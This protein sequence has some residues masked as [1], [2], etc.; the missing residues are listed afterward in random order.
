[1]DGQKV[2]RHG[3]KLLRKSRWMA[4][5][6]G[7]LGSRGKRCDGWSQIGR[8][9]VQVNHEGPPKTQSRETTDGGGDGRGNSR[10][11]VRR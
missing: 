9:V 11:C 7:N 1:M 10:C 6:V 3:K 8:K 5:K 2:E 4:K